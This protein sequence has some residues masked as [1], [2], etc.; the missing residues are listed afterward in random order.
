MYDYASSCARKHLIK[1]LFSFFYQ[2]T[3]LKTEPML[4]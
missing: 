2:C 4:H 1:L 3:F